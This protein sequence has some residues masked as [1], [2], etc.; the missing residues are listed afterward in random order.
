MRVNIDLSDI[1]SKDT[2]IAANNRQALAIKQSMRLKSGTSKMP[3]IFSYQS[4]IEKFWRSNHP[5]KEYRLL[6]QLELRFMLK[7]FCKDTN[8]NSQFQIYCE[9]FYY[10][11]FN[12]IPTPKYNNRTTPKYNMCTYYL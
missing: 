10:T 4:W 8:N 9:H 11:G 1:Q 12:K 6:S 3:K 7:K 5:T 2:I